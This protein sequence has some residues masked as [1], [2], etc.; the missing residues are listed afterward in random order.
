M[1]RPLSH[2]HSP[3]YRRRLLRGRVARALGESQVP[4]E[5]PHWVL[6]VLLDSG[7]PPEDWLDAMDAADDLVAHSIIALVIAALE[8]SHG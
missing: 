7:L 4:P 6:R 5:A 3:R 1:A 8:A 2:T